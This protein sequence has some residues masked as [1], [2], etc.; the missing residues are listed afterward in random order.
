MNYLTHLRKRI[1]RSVG[2]RLLQLNQQPL[3]LLCLLFAGLAVCKANLCEDVNEEQLEKAMNFRSLPKGGA[4]AGYYSKNTEAKDLKGCVLSCCRKPTCN[5]VFLHK[6]TCF[7]IECNATVPD[8]CDPMTTDTP[9]FESSLMIQLRSVDETSKVKEEATPSTTPSD[10]SQSEQTT[11]ADTISQSNPQSTISQSGDNSSELTD[12]SGEGKRRKDLS[13]IFGIDE[14]EKNEE[15][16]LKN[17]RARLG[18]CNCKDGFSRD[19]ATQFCEIGTSGSTEPTPTS[20]DTGSS[21]SEPSSSTL[22]TTTVAAL[23]AASVTLPLIVNASSTA[24]NVSTTTLPTTTLLPLVVSAGTNKDIQLPEN[25]VTLTAFA[26][27]KATKGEKYKYEWSMESGPRGSESGKMVGKNTP[28][29]QLT[30]LIAGLYEFKV[31]VTGEAK[32]GEGHVNVTVLPPKRKNTPPVAVIKP[33][34]QRI[35][36]PNSA[37]L[38]GSGSKDDDKI[39]SYY[40]EE[41][42]GPLESSDFKDSDKPLLSLKNLSP[43][44]Y[45]F[46]LTVTDSDGVTDSTYANVTVIKETDYRPQANAGSTQV[47]SL[48]KN[49]ITLYGNASSDD[50]GIASYEWIKADDKL[51]ADMQGVRT[52]FLHLSNLQEGDYTFTL[53]VTDTSGQTD[54]ADVHVFVKPEHNQAPE[55][56]AGEDQTVMIPENQ[57]TTLDGRKSTDDKKITSYQWKQIKGPNTADI[58]HED[59]AVATVTN[60]VIGEYIFEL[61]VADKEGLTGKDRL[62]VLVQEKKNQ[63]PVASAGGDQLLTMPVSLVKLD[64]SGSKDDRAIASYLWE[65]SEDSLAAGKILNGSDHMPVLLMTDMVPGHYMFTLTVTD[66]DGLSSKDAA[67]VIIKEDENSKNLLQMYLDVDIAVFKEKNKQNLANQLALLLQKTL[68]GGDTTVDIRNIE[69]DMRTGQVI[70]TFLV[71]SEFK[72]THLTHAGT[73]IVKILKQ[74]LKSDA[75][76]LEFEVVQLDTLVCQNNCSGHGRCDSYTKQCVCDA[77]W[78]ENFFKAALEKDYNCDWSI[79]YVVIV[80][81]VI[82]ITLAAIIW[83]VYYCAKRCKTRPRKRHRYQLLSDSLQKDDME[84]LPKGKMVNG[85]IMASESELSSGEET[86]FVNQKKQNGHV[87]KPMNG[88]ITRQTN[89]NIA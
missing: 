82:V 42:S 38:D 58:I 70:V 36:L 5:V 6:K 7:L 33:A 20:S 11:S 24:V 88:L 3:L 62:K 54:T 65:K 31:T 80:I 84:M 30:E 22:S 49:S 19:E 86:L 29:L 74:R 81:F 32:Y 51:T 75:D 26:L 71:R 79:L 77:F 16:V 69:Q 10:Q 47:I 37:I 72:D 73:K 44:E 28:T 64:G 57:S 66:Q 59:Q 46:K 55:A 63:P 21:N 34:S 61:V 60:L 35:E 1:S 4:S 43:G 27:P 9:E 85:N 41:V 52:P 48:P 15:C 53:K 67:S 76:V 87:R 50:K 12:Q 23:A 39:V 14:C 40:W 13:C 56:N 8:A 2:I 83:G 17:G 25:S 45:K 18:K 68:P 89:K 78:M